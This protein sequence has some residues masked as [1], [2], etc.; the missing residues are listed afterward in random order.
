MSVEQRGEAPILKPTLFM[1]I[2]VHMRRRGP[3]L[4][5]GQHKHQHLL[6]GRA[7]GAAVY[8]LPLLTAVLEGVSDTTS[9]DQPVAN[10]MAEEY[11]TQLLM[12]LSPVFANI[13]SESASASGG[14]GTLPVEGGVSVTVHYAPHDF[15]PQ[16]LDECTRE[17]LP[18]H[19][20]HA[21]IRDELKYFEQQSVGAIGCAQ[22]VW[23][24]Q[25]QG[26]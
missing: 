2:Y 18:S 19:S 23:G 14:P 17:P 13:E 3:R 9:A 7:A 20:V 16:H 5:S 1:S 8:L 12:T 4:C 11:D 22:G 26:D 21:A 25:F 15:K 6:S 10:L 24:R